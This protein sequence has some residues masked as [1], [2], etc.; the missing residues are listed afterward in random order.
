MA[1]TDIGTAYFFLK[2]YAE[3]AEAFEK[4]VALSPNDTQLIVNLGDAYRALG[5]ADKA[6]EQ[7]QKAIS[8]GYRELQTNPQDA[9][10]LAEIAL[11]YAKVGNAQD[12]ESFIKRARTEHKDD[13]DILYKEACVNALIG[14]PSR[15]L[16]LLQNALE[17]H[18]SAEYASADL[19]LESLHNNPEFDKLIKEYSK[20]AP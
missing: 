5:Q 2:R 3:A 6:R 19:D 10:V 1:Y 20:K 17:K 15:A 14:K 7:Y 9:A 12:A 18:Y 8:V 11:S 16:E 4:A 13:V